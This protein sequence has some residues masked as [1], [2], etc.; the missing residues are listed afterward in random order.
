MLFVVGLDGLGG[1][2]GLESGVQRNSRDAVDPCRG[3][4]I[5]LVRLEEFLKFLLI[6]FHVADQEL[7]RKADEPER[8]FLQLF[9]EKIPEFRIG[10]DHIRTDHL[11][12]L[13]HAKDLAHGVFVVAQNIRNPALKG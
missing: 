9:P 8:E 3:Q 5:F 10:H 13:F 11:R 6:D 2:R 1:H 12:G 7:R 4:K